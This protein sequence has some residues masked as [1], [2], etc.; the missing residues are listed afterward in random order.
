MKQEGVLIIFAKAPVAGQ[1]KTRLIPDI[2]ADKA[3]ALYIE[4]LNKT[5]ATSIKSEFQNIQLWISGNLNHPYFDDLKNEERIE[6][7]K[8]SGKDLGERMYNAFNAALEYYS[9]AVLIGTDCPSLSRSDLHKAMNYLEIGDE[10]VLGPAK[11][12]GYYL[13]GL[14]TND[15]ALFSDIEW[16]KE[17]VFKETCQRAKKIN[18]NVNLLPMHSDID[19]VSDL[20]GFYKIKEEESL[21]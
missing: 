15:V 6:L 21:L 19:C 2:G 8:Q 4:M 18:R 12:G 20:A 14:R 10:L 16:G 3:T 17:Y 11:D 7:H 9:Y 13:I 5:L 1:V